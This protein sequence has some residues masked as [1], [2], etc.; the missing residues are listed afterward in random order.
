MNKRLRKKLR[1]EEALDAARR[2]VARFPSV[3]SLSQYGHIPVTLL[4]D[5]CR[6]EEALDE[7]EKINE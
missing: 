6:L 7:L 3:Q 2:V 4:D 1:T 5:W